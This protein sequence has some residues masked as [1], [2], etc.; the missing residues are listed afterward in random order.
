L[1]A[2]A[3][4]LLLAVAA[5]IAAV[6]ATRGSSSTKLRTFT[7]RIENVLGQS[8]S[9]RREIF[10]ALEN[11]F[12][13]KI[14]PGDAAQRIA[15]VADNRESILL[16]LGNFATP[17]AQADNVV[18]LLQKSLQQS[19]EA[20]RHYRDGF[21]SVRANEC[22]VRPN[23]DIKLGARTSAQATA[24]KRRFVAAFNPLAGRFH[25]RTWKANGF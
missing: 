10:R 13:C 3:A 25:L 20:D 23:A 18:T 5:A 2:A 8:A 21:A 1:I 15:S 7:E 22:P 16:Q 24:T 14:P 19:I 17:T 12:T 4:V 6:L 11:G 9:G